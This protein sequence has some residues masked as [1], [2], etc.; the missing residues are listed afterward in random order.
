MPPIA[1]DIIM[2]NENLVR[3]CLGKKCQLAYNKRKKGEANQ[4][5]WKKISIFFSLPYWEDHKLQHNLD[6]RQR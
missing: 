1:L 3:C 5:V 6:M 2:Q 4:C